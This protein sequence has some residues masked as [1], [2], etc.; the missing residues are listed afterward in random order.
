MDEPISGFL[1]TDKI[2]TVK[3]LSNSQK[4]N[5]QAQNSFLTHFLENHLP[6]RALTYEIFKSC[7]I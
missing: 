5:T 2:V 6:W 7:Y 4:K 1:K 3:N